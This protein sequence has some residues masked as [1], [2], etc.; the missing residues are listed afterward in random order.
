M[1]R[2]GFDGI[3]RAGLLDEVSL[4]KS[5]ADPDAAHF[6]CSI[7][8]AEGSHDVAMAGWIRFARFKQGRAI[9]RMT[10]WKVSRLR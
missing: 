7:T 3:Y 5:T 10:G 1:S 2:F 8:W 9:I 6:S 4:L